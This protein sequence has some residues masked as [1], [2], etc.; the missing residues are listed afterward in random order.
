L[1]LID[2]HIPEYAGGNRQNHEPRRARKLLVSRVEMNKLI[3]AVTREGMALVPLQLYFNA[4]GI[5]KRFQRDEAAQRLHA[6]CAAQQQGDSARCIATGFHFAAIGVED[7]HLGVG[8]IRR[9]NQ[10]QLIAANASTPIGNGAGA[11]R[12]HVHGCG[13]P[14]NDDKVIAQPVHLVKNIR[15][16]AL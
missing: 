1:W 16:A 13:S 2:A 8:V 7:A 4:R 14:I 6:R 9:A 10:D 12:G 15:H 3:G 11:G 5:A